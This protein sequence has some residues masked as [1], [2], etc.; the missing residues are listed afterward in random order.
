MSQPQ[1]LSR[2]PSFVVL[3]QKLTMVHLVQLIR[4]CLQGEDCQSRLQNSFLH[5]THLIQ[6]EG[7][8]RTET[9]VNPCEL[10]RVGCIIWY[11]GAR[12]QVASH[13]LGDL[14]GGLQEVPDVWLLT[15]K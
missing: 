10:R 1:W 2:E 12:I 7:A 14:I 8:T 15:W 5:F 3:D 9:I 6:F 4:E 13:E 11:A